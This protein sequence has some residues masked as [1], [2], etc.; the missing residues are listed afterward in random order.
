MNNVTQS[1]GSRAKNNNNMSNH[2]VKDESNASVTNSDVKVSQKGIVNVSQNQLS[3]GQKGKSSNIMN[4]SGSGSKLDEHYK[5]KGLFRKIKKTQEEPTNPKNGRKIVFKKSD[6][7]LVKLK[8]CD[9]N[10]KEERLKYILVDEDIKQ[11]LKISENEL[12][13]FCDNTDYENVDYKKYEIPFFLEKDEKYSIYYNSIPIR[14]IKVQGRQLNFYKAINGLKNQKYSIECTCKTNPNP[15]VKRIEKKSRGIYNNGKNIFQVLFKKSTGKTFVER[16]AFWPGKAEY[17]FYQTSEMTGKSYQEQIDKQ[18]IY[19]KGYGLTLEEINVKM[20]PKNL[21]ITNKVHLA[22]PECVEQGNF[23][24]GFNHRCFFFTDPV[25][26]FFLKCP[27]DDIIACA[28]TELKRQPKY[29]FIYSHPNAMDLS[30]SVCGFPNISDL[31]R[32]LEVN[33]MAYDY[34]GYG[35]SNGKPSEEV[36]K[37]NLRTVI[38]YINKKKKV[39]INRIV[40]FGYSIG[41]SL[42]AIIATEYP[43]LA[44]L[45][46]FGAPASL[47]TVVKYQLFNSNIN[48]DDD[49]CGDSFNTV[50]AIANVDVPTLIVQSKIDKMVPHSN[51]FAIYK[52][53]KN[54]LPPYLLSDIKHNYMDTSA[55]ALLKVKEFI[56]Y[57]LKQDPLK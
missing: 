44:G 8:F 14:P 47:S 17:F 18:I 37:E 48:V 36:L 23:L 9:G 13:L 52:K 26:F 4:I 21:N 24:F 19:T 33:F 25:E 1:T 28:Y 7:K 55:K 49:V 51:G 12:Y 31:A 54:P 29:T 46:L 38:E 41:A 50:K 6:K 34:S 45:I 15:L 56:Q 27:N 5:K 57:T 32:F 2:K 3:R 39:P 40:L 35:I 42:S 30:D 20:N 43:N 16:C 11:D 53:A 22:T 10:G